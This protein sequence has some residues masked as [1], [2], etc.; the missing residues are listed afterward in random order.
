MKKKLM[1]AT[2]VAG[3]A[4][5]L[6]ACSTATDADVASR[7]LSQ[8]AD[9]FEIVRRITFM[10]TRLGTEPLVIEGKCSI[11]DANNQ[12]EATCKTPDG[13][14]LKHFLG[15]C[16]DVTYIAEQLQSKDVS[17]SR[18]RVDIK[19]SAVIPDVRFR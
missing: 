17:T 6:T 13:E 8:A 3:A 10:N 15:L 1:A 2:L 18:Y 14:Y 12:L 19:P 11:T 7:N 9:Q 4:L 16:N 5:G